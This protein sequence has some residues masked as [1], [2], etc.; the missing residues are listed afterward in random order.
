[1]AKL[2]DSGSR[3][4]VKRRRI[5]SRKKGRLLRSGLRKSVLTLKLL[6]NLIQMFS[7]LARQI[8]IGIKT[9]YGFAD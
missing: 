4:K 1:M 8:A 9:T 7:E 6:Q 3:G 5:E 2:L